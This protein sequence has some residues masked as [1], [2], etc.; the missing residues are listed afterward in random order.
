MPRVSE[1]H[2]NARRQQILDAAAACFAREG[3]HRTSMQDIVRECGVSAGLVYRYFASK[4]EMIEAIVGEWHSHRVA[5]LS[6]PLDRAYLELLREIGRPEA[7]DGRLALQVWAE[8]VRSPEIRALSRGNVDAMRDAL[9]AQLEGA[10]PAGFDPDPLVRVMIA[11]YQ[12]LIVQTVWDEN[13][14]NDAF[15]RTV[16][17]LIARIL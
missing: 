9:V 3:F 10:L 7:P 17:A 1:A 2:L 13:L 8:S 6:V 5:A 15:V 11:I 4:D 14:D 16:A 12:G